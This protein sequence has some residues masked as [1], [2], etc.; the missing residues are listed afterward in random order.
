MQLQR[1]LSEILDA[2]A[3]QLLG[4]TMV[5]VLEV[6][7]TPDLGLAK[8]YVSLFNSENKEADLLVLNNNMPR[9]RHFLAGKLK[10]QVRKIPELMFFLDDRIDRAQYME[11]LLNKIRKPE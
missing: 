4:N 5:T 9:I 7:I 2:A 3:K 10:N 8:V 6:V 11:E 1:D